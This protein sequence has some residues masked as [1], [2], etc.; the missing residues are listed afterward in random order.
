MRH[1]DRTQ[2]NDRPDGRPQNHH[3]FLGA[4]GESPM[5][6]L[7]AKLHRRFGR[8][9][10]TRS[11][12]HFRRNSLSLLEQLEQREVLTVVF[13]P[14]F[15][16]ETIFWRANNTAGHPANQVVT[17]PITNPTALNNPT[18]YFIFW[19]TTWANSAPELASDAK[20]IIQSPFL[21]GLKQYGSS[22]TATYGGY[23]I[24]D[25]ADPTASATARDQEIQK[26][27]PTMTSW[28]KPKDASALDSPVYVVVFDNGN[29]GQNN[30]S[31]YG[32]GLVA[33]AIFIGD[34]QN[35]QDK[36]TDLLSHELAE[37]MSDGTGYG[38]GMNGPAGIPGDGEYKNAQISD[39]EPD[40]H[41]YTYRLD[42][43]LLVQAYWSVVNQAFIIPDGTTQTLYLS[44]N[45]NT[46]VSPPNFLKNFELT[47]EGDQ[48][49]ANY[50]DAV[51]VGL[52]GSGGVQVTLNGEAYQFD[53]GAIS[54][55]DIITKGGD[56][57]VN[58]EATAPN[59]P[60][61]I[62]ML[63]GTGTVNISPAAENL[64]ALAGALTVHG[65]GATHLVVDDQ[66]ANLNVGSPI[67]TQDILTGTTLT[68]FSQSIIPP[69]Y[70]STHV[71]T[72]TYDGLAG[73]TLNTG[74][75]PNLVLV[76]GTSTA[77]TVNAGSGNTL[78]AVSPTA[79]NLD[80][81]TGALTV[82]GGGA[83]HL[84]V[85]DQNANLNDGIPILTQD[86]LTGTTL[87]R[88]S[89]SMSIVP[90]PPGFLIPSVRVAMITYDGLAGLTLNTGVTA[91]VVNVEGTS[92]ATTVNAGS[93][94]T[95]VAV[96]P[97]AENLDALTGALTVHG[98][99]ATH[100]VVDDQNANLNDG[101]PI[102][103]QDILTGTTLTRFSQSIIPPAYPSIRGAAITYDGL[104]G[105]TLNTGVTA[106]VV[107][108]EGTST[109]TTVN[110]GS[111]NTLVAV[112]PT[113][114]N[115][116]ALTGALTVHGGGATHL[117]VDDQNNLANETYT[118]TSGTFQRT[119]SA[120]ITYG[121]LSSLSVNG[122][123]GADKY[124]IGGTSNGVA[125]TINGGTGINTLVGPDVASTWNITGA[126]AG[127][128]GT[129]TFAAVENLTGGSANDAFKFAAGGS[130]TGK[131]NGGT[132]TNTLDYSGDGGIAAT[133]NLAT[134]TATKTGGF[135]NIQQVVG[136]SAVNNALIGANTTNTWSLTGTNAGTLNGFSFSA[137]ENLT[138]GT[139]VDAFVFGAGAKITGKINGGGGGDWLDYAAYTTPV[140][141]NL[142]SGTA[143]SVGGGLTNIQDVRGG[144]G[145]NT[146]TGDA[147][148][149]ILIGGAGPNTITGGTGRSILIGG[150]G[151][152]TVTGKSGNDILIAG[153]TDYDS[154]TLAHDQALES[155]LAEWQSG[156]LYTTRVSKIKSGVGPGNADKLVWGVTVHDNSTANANKLTGGGGASGQNWFFANKSHT[157]TN[158]TGS[159]QLN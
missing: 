69:G 157:T 7:F 51:T 99:G 22:G 105:L 13:E 115:L 23:T 138:G 137:V 48:L 24:D 2:K 141:V 145:G 47:I 136:S 67:L 113:A 139:S 29:K 103:T 90:V 134:L 26:I 55:I 57:T 86:I 54:S 9:Q 132:G 130:V 142:A 42:G 66:N 15:G 10:R 148:G 92:T 33:N 71:A 76:E 62:S 35:S 114:E 101:I 151:K 5:E 126:N 28:A 144:Q 121:G 81:L 128:V 123:H 78:V 102:L 72:I 133:V 97:T 45:W 12:R 119:G 155:I 74:A 36:F 3:D 87:T 118:I 43:T 30:V 38:I 135:A 124:I 154:S 16:A 75:T 80:A 52:T 104:A 20:T 93:G 11:A 140:A 31:K 127:T 17:G 41:R 85:D 107:N 91:N 77:T 109:A 147:Q 131:I 89:Q 158:K 19:G 70:P 59:V 60:V 143:T 100:L 83:T 25:S 125:T 82:H 68:R 53:K 1:V 56:N 63:G 156:D 117:V 95:L 58:I 122:G 149:N 111:G 21:S 108:V 34:G 4:N 120:S 94:N 49:G 153:Y 150:K 129:V 146:L 116:D 112:S 27:V 37:R 98:G 18:V 106:N 6:T 39:N 50:N 46:Q 79:E 14:V 152:D 40:E 65:G 32:Q 44:P 64:D 88:T 96:S 110:A 73:L 61:S 159:E 8:Q 84:V